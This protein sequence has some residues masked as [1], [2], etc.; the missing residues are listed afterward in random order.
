[1]QS[2]FENQVE[3]SHQLDDHANDYS[4][5]HDEEESYFRTSAA[6]PLPKT[7]IRRTESENNLSENLRL[8]EFRD[9]CMFDRL[10]SGIHKQQQLLYNAEMHNR[11]RQDSRYRVSRHRSSDEGGVD[12]AYFHSRGRG[13]REN[14]SPIVSSSSGYNA[15]SQVVPLSMKASYL[16]ENKKS[17]ESII[18]TRRQPVAFR[19]GPIACSPL[20]V[21]E[22]DDYS[23]AYV[24]TDDED[25]SDFGPV[26]EMEI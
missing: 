5:F 8:A 20:A 13:G 15:R 4:F 24:V 23:A 6:I 9:Q 11:G 16:E 1:M 7:H 19:E 21:E 3:H 12:Q 25:C 22:E 26:F 14:P 10:V 2:I 17:I 18:F